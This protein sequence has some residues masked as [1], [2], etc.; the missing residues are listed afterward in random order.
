VRALEARG[1]LGLEWTLTGRRPGR[2]TNAGSADASGAEAANAIASGERPDGRPLGARQLRSST[3]SAATTAGELPAADLG[4]R[5]GHAAVAGLVR[6]GLVE[7][8]IRERPRRPLARRRPAGAAAAHRPPTCCRP[9]A[10]AVDRARAAIAARTR[11]R[12]CS[13]ASRAA[14]RP[15]ST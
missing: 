14:A 12:C 1:L 3:S 6:R 8:E 7:S 5:H 10:E 9:Q 15:R 2:G 4:G 11:A 13:T